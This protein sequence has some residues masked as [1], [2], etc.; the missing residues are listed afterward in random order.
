MLKNY[1]YQRNIA[2]DI[3][4]INIYYIVCNTL[5]IVIKKIKNTKISK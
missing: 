4:H 5:F 1:I 3:I 2:I